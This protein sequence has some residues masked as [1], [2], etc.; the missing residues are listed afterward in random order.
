M[1]EDVDQILTDAAERWQ[2]AQP[3]PPEPD[4]ARWATERTSLWR[5]R[6]ARFLTVGVVAAA[7]AA[8]IVGSMALWPEAAGGPEQVPGSTTAAP[9]GRPDPATLVVRDGDV[10]EAAGEVEVDE[11][12]PVRFCPPAVRA[13]PVRALPA[14]CPFALTATGVDLDRLANRKVG[15]E[16]RLSGWAR[17]RGVYRA[18]TLAVTEQWAELPENKPPRRPTPAACQPPSGG[19]RTGDRANSDRLGQFVSRHRDRFSGL[20]ITHPAGAPASTMVI[21]VGVVGEDPAT[22]QAELARLYDGNV[23]VVA[24]RNTLATLDRVRWAAADVMGDRRSTIHSVMTG[25]DDAGDARVAVGMVRL[26]A[27]TYDRL[28]PIGFDRLSLNPW[29][30]PVR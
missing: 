28:R 13:L 21:V 25:D 4:Q 5:P 23:C 10:V 12:K 3:P 11:G 19:W 29:L 18:G 22:V 17:L 26:D 30:R 2:A 6:A 9:T 24:A 15:A 27:A 20:D 1:N 7:V 8:T 16:G 14:P